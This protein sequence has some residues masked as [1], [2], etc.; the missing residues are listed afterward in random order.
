[1]MWPFSR[2]PV[3]VDVDLSEQHAAQAA[4]RETLLQLASQEQE[5]HDKHDALTTRQR[6]NNF[7]AALELAMSQRKP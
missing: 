5:V 4:A 7:G 3:D 2:K 6:K 1:M